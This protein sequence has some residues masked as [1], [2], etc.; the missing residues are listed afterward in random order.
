M[1]SY[2][3]IKDFYEYLIYD[4][5]GWAG[6]RDDAPE[7]AKKAYAEFKRKEAEAVD[8]KTGRVIRV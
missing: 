1:W 8:K 3:D 2:D 6:I 7:K 5:D 4:E